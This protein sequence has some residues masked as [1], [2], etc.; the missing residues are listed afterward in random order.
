MWTSGD[1]GGCPPNDGGSRDE[2]GSPGLPAPQHKAAATL[3]WLC[4]RCCPCPKFAPR[5][6]VTATAQAA[7]RLTRA[8]GICNGDMQP[9][10]FRSQG[11]ARRTQ[12]PSE[13]N[14]VQKRRAARDRK[15]TRT[16][17]PRADR[18][19][20][21]EAEADQPPLGSPHRRS[22]RLPLLEELRRV[23]L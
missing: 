19:R 9:S 17:G 3:Q 5:Y 11:I 6:D 22:R 2:P 13:S 7:D 18:S 1:G 15:R 12:D 14:R 8:V 10:P 4:S 21:Y 16:R 20:P 23:S